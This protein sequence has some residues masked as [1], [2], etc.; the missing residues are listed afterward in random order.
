MLHAYVAPCWEGCSSFSLV[1]TLTDR[2]LPR[3]RIRSMQQCCIE[4]DLQ[5]KKWPISVVDWKQKICTS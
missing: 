5:G 3:A 1:P 2:R 4:Q